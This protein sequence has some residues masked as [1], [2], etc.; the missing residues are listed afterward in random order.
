[1]NKLIAFILILIIAPILGGIYGVIHDQITYS[2]SEEYYTKF[3]FIQFGLE[4]WGMGQNIGT[5]RT[6]EIELAN[7]RLGAAIVGVLATWWV[8]LIIGIFL[9]FIG[10]IHRNGKEMLNI[11]LKAFLLTIG[12]ALLT[13]LI[14]LLYGKIFLVDNP[15]NWFLPDNLIERGSFIMVGSMHNFSYL[16]GLIGLISAITYSIR[17]KRGYKNGKQ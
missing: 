11:S 15:P 16:G 2:I 17:Q 8:G 3:K 9:G 13:G 14:G 4:N 5:I 12:I 10:L 1:M 6:P 7:P